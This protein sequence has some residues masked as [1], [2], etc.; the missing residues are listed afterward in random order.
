MMK[1]KARTSIG[2]YI[3]EGKV[4]DVSVSNDQEQYLIRCD[5]GIKDFV[6]MSHFSVVP[7]TPQIEVGSE[8][9]GY[10]GLV[11]S[12]VYIGDMIVVIKEKNGIQEIGVDKFSMTDIYKPKSKTVTMYFYKSPHGYVAYSNEH[13]FYTIAFK[14]EIEL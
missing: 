2:R 1:V 4:Y 5:H 12:V 3:T 10:D 13:P 8:W 14:K 11:Y 7:D 9:V 6:H